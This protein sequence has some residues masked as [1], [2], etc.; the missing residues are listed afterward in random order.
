[1]I[2]ELIILLNLYTRNSNVQFSIKSRAK[3]HNTV[4]DIN[5][6]GACGEKG[7]DPFSQSLKIFKF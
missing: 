1:M 7:I 4:D 5:I 6:R 3:D 2:L